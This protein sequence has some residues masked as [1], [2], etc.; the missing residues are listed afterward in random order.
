MKKIAIALPHD[1]KLFSV[2]TM[3]DVIE[4]ANNINIKNK[5]A[6]AFSIT[7]V[8]SPEQIRNF[9]RTFHGYPVRSINNFTAADIVLIPSFTTAEIKKTVE[10][11][12]CFIPW[13]QKQSKAGA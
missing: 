4:T 3:V 10:K 9:G 8:Q 2:A 12:K 6:A 7:F 5:K 11:N 1:Y 13:L